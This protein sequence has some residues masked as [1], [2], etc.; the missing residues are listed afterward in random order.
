MR[1]DND[2]YDFR[3]FGLAIKEARNKQG[4]TRNK[5]AEI[6]QI[7]PR[8]L[9]NIENKGQ[10]PSL[11]VL[12]KLVTYF[13]LSVDQF[14]YPDTEPEKSTR[15]RQVD[16]ILNGFDDIDLI[17]VAATVNGISEAKEAKQL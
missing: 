15:R 12:Y 5:A 3:A 16:M 17:I 2:V 6:I 8:Y 7:D 11:K 14:F 4:M 1:K 10:H 13:N 9:T